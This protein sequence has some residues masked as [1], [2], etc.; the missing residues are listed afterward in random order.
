MRSA[1][2]PSQSG[3]KTHEKAWRKEALYVEEASDQCGAGRTIAL[4]SRAWW[5]PCCRTCHLRFRTRS[6]LC[7][8]RTGGDCVSAALR[9]RFQA[10]IVDSEMSRGKDIAGDASMLSVM[11]GRCSST[12]GMR[13]GCVTPHRVAGVVGVGDTAGQ[14]LFV[15]F[16]CRH[17]RRESRESLKVNP[18]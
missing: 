15:R 9:L 1:A 11:I 17:L 16:S 10:S 6:C 5:R 13:S 3:K 7:C 4:E 8:V 2:L 12:S 18:S 14:G